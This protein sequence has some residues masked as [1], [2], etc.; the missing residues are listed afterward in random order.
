MAKFEYYKNM[1]DSLGD[2]KNLEYPATLKIS[3]VS[4]STN[5]MSLNDESANEIVKFLKENY[6]IVDSENKIDLNV[7]DHFNYWLGENWSNQS[8]SQ[9]YAMVIDLLNK[10]NVKL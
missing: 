10:V 5:N 6:N 8:G 4:K 9:I 3:T 1:L 7:V 2:V